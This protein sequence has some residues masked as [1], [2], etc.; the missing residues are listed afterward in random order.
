VLGGGWGWSHEPVVH[1]QDVP[2]HHLD[3]ELA[4]FPSCRGVADELGGVGQQRQRQW[5]GVQDA[6]YVTGDVLDGAA[7][8][9]AADVEPCPETGQ[10]HLTAQVEFPTPV[11][12]GPWHE[13]ASEHGPWHE[14]AS[15]SFDQP[16]RRGRGLSHRGL[17]PAGV[18]DEFHTDGAFPEVAR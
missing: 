18:R 7:L 13:P 1:V 4:P 16:V 6:A 5:V 10:F 3:G 9:A 8:E 11:G 14:P 2:L 12:H 17:E 15:E